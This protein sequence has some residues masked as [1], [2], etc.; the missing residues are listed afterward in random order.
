MI[1]L[2]TYWGGY[3]QAYLLW[4]FEWGGAGCNPGDDAPI[5]ITRI[6]G[7]LLSQWFPNVLILNQFTFKKSSET[8]HPLSDNLSVRILSFVGLPQH[9]VSIYFIQCITMYY[10]FLHICLCPTRLSR[11]ENR[12]Y[13][14]LFSICN[15]KHIIKFN[16]HWTLSLL[17]LLPKA[18]PG[19]QWKKQLI[20]MKE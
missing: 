15:T 20:T 11:L 13:G 10:N 5:I 19:T 2:F 18:V 14:L 6:M 16:I 8:P 17:F 12:D 4:C 9:Q 3:R 7:T 1:L